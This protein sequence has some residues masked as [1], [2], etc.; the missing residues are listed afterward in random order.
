LSPD[1]FAELTARQWQP[2]A[3]E[4][5]I[6]QH[7][8]FQARKLFQEQ[9]QCSK[10]EARKAVHDMAIE[11]RQR[12]SQQL[13][14]SLPDRAQ[15]AELGISGKRSAAITVVS[16]QT[17]ASP[18]LAADAVMIIT[19]EA[20]H[21]AASKLFEHHPELGT[22]ILQT[23]QQ[24]SKIQAIKLYREQTGVSLKEAKDAVERLAA[25]LP[26]QPTYPAQSYQHQGTAE[27]ASMDEIYRL[28]HE[29]RKI[30]A[31]KLY[32]EQTGVSLKEAKDAVERLAANQPLGASATQVPPPPPTTGFVDPA[33][34][35][36]LVAS[37][38]KIQAIKYFR[39]NTGAGLK[40]ARDAVEWL[41][42]QMSS[43]M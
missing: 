20:Q 25:G 15:I 42:T 13:I 23:L 32:R 10:S 39:E 8:L 14:A 19:E 40:E 27:A 26:L 7:Q 37:G 3:V 36:R 24:G 4:Q 17:G 16:E 22:Q 1:K 38:N 6:Q 43:K 34:L 9:T 33:E 2:E 18:G 35:Q 41:E 31:I 5:F 21:A 29:G 30:Q 11:L 12:Q 28:V